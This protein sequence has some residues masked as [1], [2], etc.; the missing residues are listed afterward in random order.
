MLSSLIFN[1]SN[2]LQVIVDYR[3]LHQIKLLQYLLNSF[4]AKIT[5]RVTTPSLPGPGDQIATLLPR[6]EIR[7]FVNPLFL[8]Q[9]FIFLSL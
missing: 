4:N 9:Y 6:T 1:K 8:M 2:T 3:I 7:A 5:R